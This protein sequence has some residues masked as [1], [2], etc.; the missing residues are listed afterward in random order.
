MSPTDADDENEKNTNREERGADDGLSMT[1][2][3]I[4][5]ELNMS[6]QAVHQILRAALYKVKK[7]LIQRGITEG[8][9]R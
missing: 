8:R 9:W 1:L 2:E 7:R 6:K 5:A 4:A 3:Q